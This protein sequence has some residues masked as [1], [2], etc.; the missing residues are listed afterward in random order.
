MLSGG[1]INTNFTIFGLTQTGIETHDHEAN[2]LTITP[3]M[4]PDITPLMVPDITPLMVPDI[5]PLMVP[6]CLKSL[7]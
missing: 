2:K 3:L 1:R 6:E 5:T 7:L 4:V